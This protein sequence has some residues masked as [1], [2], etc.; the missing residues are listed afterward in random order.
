MS[1]G[2]AALTE[3]PSRLLS[4]YVRTE[5]NGRVVVLRWRQD[6]NDWWYSSLLRYYPSKG[7]RGG[8]AEGS[9]AMKVGD[10]YLL[11]SAAEVDRQLALFE[12]WPG[13]L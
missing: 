4:T 11:D 10:P 7:S 2:G 3:G 8:S 1:C 5:A 13:R 12:Q 9:C 6:V